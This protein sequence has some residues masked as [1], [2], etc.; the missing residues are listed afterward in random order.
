MGSAKK[1]TIA[2]AKW[3]VAFNHLTIIFKDRFNENF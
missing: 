3:Q 2:L 1:W